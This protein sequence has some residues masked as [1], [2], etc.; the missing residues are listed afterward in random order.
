M[1]VEPEDIPSPE[2]AEQRRQ[3][4]RDEEALEREIE[5]KQLAQILADEGCRDFLWR[6]LSR[7]HV[8]QT[9]YDRNFG[10]MA[11][12]EGERDV[13]LWLLN[14]I[15]EADGAAFVTMMQKAQLRAHEQARQQRPR[16]R[17]RTPPPAPSP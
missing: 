8:F 12:K 7:C 13:G 6:L 1:S 14:E 17:P 2:E 9:S 15:T 4:R 5:L 11:R 10:D 3:S 16:R